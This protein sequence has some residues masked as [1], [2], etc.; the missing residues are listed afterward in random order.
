MVF[1]TTILAGIATYTG[2][3]CRRRMGPTYVTIVASWSDEIRTLVDEHQSYRFRST[4]AT[5]SLRNVI[6]SRVALTFLLE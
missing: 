5:F 2:I 1:I 4:A 3:K 6:I